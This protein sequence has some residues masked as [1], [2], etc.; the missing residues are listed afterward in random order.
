MSWSVS[1]RGA[2]ESAAVEVGKQF[3]TCAGYYPGQL[4]CATVNACRGAAMTAIASLKPTDAQEVTVSAYG[5]QGESY[6]SAHVD[7]SLVDKP[8]PAPETKPDPNAPAAP[9]T[10]SS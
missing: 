7:V 9:A 6:C 2:K 10:S 3:D 8:A 1:Y 4:E 5:S